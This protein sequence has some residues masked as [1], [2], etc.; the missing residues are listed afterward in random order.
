MGETAGNGLE[1]LRGVIAEC[2]DAWRKDH[3]EDFWREPLIAC[4]SAHDPLMRALKTAVD[5][6]H[7]LPGDILPGA[8]SVIVFFLPFR[9]EFG[10]EN[11]S[12]GH[13]SSRNWCVLYYRTNE[14][15]REI[16]ARLREHLERAGF[17]ARVTP[18]THN[19]DTE[20]LV[21]LWSHKH[22]GYIAGLGTFGHHRLLITPEGCCGRLGSLVTSMP[23]EPTGRPEREFCLNRAGRECSACV[24]K[25]VYGA[26][27]D[28]EDA[29]DRRACYA[30]C[31]ANDAHFDDLPLVDVC[32]K[33]G[34]EVP[35]SYSAPR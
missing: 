28:S 26:L 20:K 16:T 35:C 1:R 34:C 32:G 11:D 6:A 7:A 30:Q 25:C 29:F 15:I 4:A 5:P 31:L 24:S 18:P 12:S 8:E 10:R 21:S 9:P 3:G 13:Y 17:E 33:C 27:S 14:L 19:F 22:L 2:V 23:V